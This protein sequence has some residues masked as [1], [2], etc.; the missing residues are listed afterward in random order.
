[1]LPLR[2][3]KDS[4]KKVPS[5][6]IK[7]QFRNAW[8]TSHGFHTPEIVDR[9]SIPRTPQAL[10]ENRST[11][12]KPIKATK[13]GQ[14]KRRPGKLRRLASPNFLTVNMNFAGVGNIPIRR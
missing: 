5:G 1:M 8:L 10:M 12:L 9:F 6:A 3:N 11:L 13:M 14:R 2:T 4:K 7:E